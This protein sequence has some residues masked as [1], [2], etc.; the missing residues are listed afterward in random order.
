MTYGMFVVAFAA[1][2]SNLPQIYTLFTLRVTEGLSLSTWVMYIAFAFIQLFY[3]ITNKIK[4]LIISNL[5][6]I[7]VELVMVYGI[8]SFSISKAPPEY[9][10]LLMINNLGKA[11]AGLALICISSAAALFAYDLH[12]LQH[13]KARV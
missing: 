4:P 11:V 9:E 5:L 10:Q 3:A 7:V 12:S 6:W 1:P 13:K 8:L 2:L